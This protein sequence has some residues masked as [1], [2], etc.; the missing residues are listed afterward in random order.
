MFHRIRLGTFNV[1][2]KMPTQDLSAWV[3]GSFNEKL[4]GK[5]TTETIQQENV[6]PLSPLQRFLPKN[7]LGWS[8]T[9]S[10]FYPDT[11]LE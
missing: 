3:Q 11:C 2:G 5:E 9:S 10:S 4:D 1:N 8:T 6:P 7:P